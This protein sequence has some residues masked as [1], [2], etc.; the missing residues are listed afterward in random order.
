M[1]HCT[2]K[3]AIFTKTRW[4]EGD[5]DTAWRL[6]SMMEAVLKYYVENFLAIIT[7]QAQCWVKAAHFKLTKSN[8][9][10]SSTALDVSIFNW[11]GRELNCASNVKNIYVQYEGFWC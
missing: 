10:L 7:E 3:H 1:F 4:D 6:H 11:L 8:L 2:S 5:L 9:I